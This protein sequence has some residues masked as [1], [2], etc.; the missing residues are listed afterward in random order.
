MPSTTDSLNTWIK[1]FQCIWVACG[2]IN[3]AAKSIHWNPFAK[4]KVSDL[5]QGQASQTNFIGAV[6]AQ[7]LANGLSDYPV[8]GLIAPADTFADF[9]N[10]TVGHLSYSVFDLVQGSCPP[11]CF[12]P[13]GSLLTTTKLAVAFPGRS[14]DGN[15][16]TL[17]NEVK[18]CNLDN[19][20]APTALSDAN[21]EVT[22]PAD[23]TLADLIETLS[24][25]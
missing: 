15:W 12:N 1:A 17:I 8:T 9:A 14:E 16:L 2:S 21:A 11:G 4:T 18:A 22:P 5:L 6:K 25:I 23:S 19:V 24:K 13:Q 7:F 20:L 3:T 10:D